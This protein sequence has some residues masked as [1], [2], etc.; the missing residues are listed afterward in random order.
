MGPDTRRR[1]IVGTA[2]EDATVEFFIE[3][4]GDI[5]ARVGD[6][7]VAPFHHIS[8]HVEE[9]EVVRHF[10][11]YRPALGCRVFLMPGMRAEDFD[12]LT[13][14]IAASCSCLAR[15]LPLGLGW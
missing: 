3:H 6:L 10:G 2:A 5:S 4:D 11:T 14:G 13:A 8:V 9:A 1:Q 15:V 12:N 7:F